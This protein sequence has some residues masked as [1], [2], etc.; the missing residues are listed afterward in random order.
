VAVALGQQRR[1]DPGLTDFLIFYNT[2]RGHDSL[3]GNT[4][5]SRLAA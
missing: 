5:I 3:K 2:A 4:P 1:A